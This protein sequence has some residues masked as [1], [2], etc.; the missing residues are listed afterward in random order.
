MGYTRTNEN[1]VARV[2]L[3]YRIANNPSARAF[4]Y[5]AKLKLLMIVPSALIDMILEDADIERFIWIEVDLFKQLLHHGFI[6]YKTNKNIK[7]AL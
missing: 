7:I 5:K 1:Q 4:C 6:L 3:L 2:K